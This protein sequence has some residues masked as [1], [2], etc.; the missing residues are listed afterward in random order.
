MDPLILNLESLFSTEPF[1]G[2]LDGRYAA[3]HIH[4]RESGNRVDARPMNTRFL[5]PLPEF[6]ADSYAALVRNVTGPDG[7][8]DVS[9]NDIKFMITETNPDA[10]T[11]YVITRHDRMPKADFTC[12][13]WLTVPV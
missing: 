2:L 13:A 7:Q 1:R 8:I 10:G 5:E 9:V 3:V 4:R 12:R 6:D 11:Q